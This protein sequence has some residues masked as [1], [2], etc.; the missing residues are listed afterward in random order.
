[1]HL[2]GLGTLSSSFRLYDGFSSVLFQSGGGKTLSAA[3]L[4]AIDK[5]QKD[6]LR[7]SNSLKKSLTSMRKNMA[8]GKKSLVKSA[9][10]AAIAEARKVCSMACIV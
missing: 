8:A 9:R 5:K 4:M 3:A 6:L 10:G 7:Y 2:L 1:M